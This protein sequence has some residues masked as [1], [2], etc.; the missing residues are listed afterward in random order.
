MYEDIVSWEEEMVKRMMEKGL[1]EEEA[2]ARVEKIHMELS[3]EESQEHW[4]VKEIRDVAE[5]ILRDSGWKVKYVGW[6]GDPDD[7]FYVEFEVIEEGEPLDWDYDWSLEERDGKKYV[8]H[9]WWY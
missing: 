4:R 8:R 6:K 2:W 1:S 3:M 5:E 7:H 9:W